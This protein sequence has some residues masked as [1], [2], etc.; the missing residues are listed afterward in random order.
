MNEFDYN[1]TIP[2]YEKLL[3]D[4]NSMEYGVNKEINEIIT[5]IKNLEEKIKEI[6]LDWGMQVLNQKATW[7]T[8]VE[9]IEEMEKTI[10]DVFYD[11]IERFE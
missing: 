10:K 5:D 8:T 3:T 4:E 11:I 7:E 6:R 1:N 9:M 2:S